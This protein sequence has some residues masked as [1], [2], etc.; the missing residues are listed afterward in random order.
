[1]ELLG[2][3]RGHPRNRE[4]HRLIFH[5]PFM[6][7]TPQ[8]PYAG[9]R[10]GVALRM[11]ASPASPAAPPP[12]PQL[13]PRPRG[14]G[15]SAGFCGAPKPAWQRLGVFE[16]TDSKATCFLKKLK[17]KCNFYFFCFSSKTKENKTNI[18]FCKCAF[19]QKCPKTKKSKNYL[20]NKKSEGI[21]CKCA[22]F[23]TC[24]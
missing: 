16:K 4:V 10:S 2:S 9:D 23:A 14:A 13:L 12:P 19:F 24:L 21:F 6:S 22:F 17:T 7:K 18:Y 3:P 20:K 11:A 15:V 8:S 1:M 5:P